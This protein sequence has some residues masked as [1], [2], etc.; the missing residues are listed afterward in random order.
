MMHGRGEL[1]SATVAGKPTNKA[2]AH[3]RGAGGAKG[4]GR[5]ECEP[6]KHGPGTEPGNRVTSAGAHTASSKTKEE[7]VHPAPAP[8]QHRNCVFSRGIPLLLLLL[9]LLLLPACCSQLPPWRAEIVQRATVAVL[10]AIYEED[11]LGFSNGFRPR[12]RHARCV[13]CARRRDQEHEGELDTGRRY[14]IILR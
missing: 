12:A 3:R 4:G 10:N 1:D 7:V 13:G 2:E 11:F 9:L 8:H 6:A 14:P 5:G